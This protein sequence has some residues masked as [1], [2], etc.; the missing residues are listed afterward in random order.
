MKNIKPFKLNI[1]VT[2]IEK[3]TKLAL[4]LMSTVIIFTIKQKKILNYV[5]IEIN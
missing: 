1:A 2:K 4:L 3:R 5:F